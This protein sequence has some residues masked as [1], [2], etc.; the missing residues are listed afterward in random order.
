MPHACLCS[1]RVRA[2]AR[3]SR[4]GWGF[5][6]EVMKP[7]QHKREDLSVSPGFG[8]VH[9]DSSIGN[10]ESFFIISRV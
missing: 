1:P 6:Q 5:K 3:V 4:V 7:L 8:R 10:H 2:L 9:G